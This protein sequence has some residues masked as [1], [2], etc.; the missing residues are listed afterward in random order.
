VRR[1][2]RRLRTPCET[3]PCRRCHRAGRAN[4]RERGQWHADRRHRWSTALIWSL[5]AVTALVWLALAA[6]VVTR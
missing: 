2:L 6:L 1:L 5:V 4:W 3:W